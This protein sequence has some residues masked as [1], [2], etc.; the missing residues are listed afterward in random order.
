V[1]GLVSLPAYLSVDLASLNYLPAELTSKNHLA[2]DP[3]MQKA[4]TII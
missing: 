3:I 2:E 1:T 4:A